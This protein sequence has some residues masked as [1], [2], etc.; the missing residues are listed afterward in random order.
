MLNPKIPPLQSVLDTNL[1]ARYCVTDSILHQTIYPLCVLGVGQ[2]PHDF[3]C[4]AGGDTVSVIYLRQCHRHRPPATALS[5]LCHQSS[6][7]LP[8]ENFVLE[9]GD[10]GPR[11]KK[12]TPGQPAPAYSRGLRIDWG[13]FI[14]ISVHN[15]H[16]IKKW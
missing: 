4:S 14:D 6:G 1:V 7:D 8:Y 5:G 9:S 10:F 3:S 16:S 2:E 12:K 11:I 13:R 15:L